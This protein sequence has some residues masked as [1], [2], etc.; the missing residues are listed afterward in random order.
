MLMLLL[1][2]YAKKLVGVRVGARPAILFTLSNPQ[3]VRVGLECAIITFLWVGGQ[4][5]IAQMIRVLYTAS[6]HLEFFVVSTWYAI[7]NVWGRLFL[8]F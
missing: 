6:S 8:S 7:E 5:A 1:A 3:E 4:S 2:D